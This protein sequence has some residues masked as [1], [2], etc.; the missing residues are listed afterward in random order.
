MLPNDWNIKLRGEIK[1]RYFRDLKTFLL[2]EYSLYEVYP[3]WPDV[4]RALAL[5]PFQK[6]RVVILGQDPYHS[7]NQAN[8][9]AFSVNAGC[10]YPPS[11]QNI[12][13]ELK[14][15]VGVEATSGGLS[16]WAS[17]G[18]LLLN[19]CLTVRHGS[20]G[21]H[22]NQG[23]EMFTGKI[24][25]LLSL[26]KDPPIFVLWGRKAQQAFKKYATQRIALPNI[27]APHPSPYSARTGFFGSQ[28]FSKIN[29]MLETP[30][31][32]RTV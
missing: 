32:W 6:T 23:W 5:T 24:I 22:F 21:S 31:D 12:F 15:D 7:E 11:L 8:G 9:L 28:P 2:E 1:T 25:N 3:K 18:V 16:T 26:R 20:P 29:E 17:Q 27:K 14:S 30:I 13:K 10:A 4:F 19:V